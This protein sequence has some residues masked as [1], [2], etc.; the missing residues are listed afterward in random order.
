MPNLDR[1]VRTGRAWS[2]PT[3]GLE[4]V[5]LFSLTRCPPM[6]ALCGTCTCAAST[7]DTTALNV[8]RGRRTACGKREL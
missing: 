6:T 3:E 5:V 4:H 1:G 8:G 2:P 7:A